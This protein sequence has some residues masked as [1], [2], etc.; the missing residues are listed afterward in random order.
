MQMRLE[1]NTG[2]SRE[3]KYKPITLGF[4]SRILRSIKSA[5]LF[6]GL[7]LG[8][9]FIPV[10]HFFLVPTFLILA[11]YFGFTKFIE[12][13]CI[14]LTGELCPCCDKSIKETIVF[15]K[16]ENFRIYCYECRSQLRVI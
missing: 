7:A 8:S 4:N 11:F 3:L 15:F 5:S 2:K 12:S 13:K 1:G 6:F 14:D 10:L 16:G 9:V